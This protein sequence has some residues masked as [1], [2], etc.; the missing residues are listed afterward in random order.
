MGERRKISSGKSK[1]KHNLSK[2]NN[3]VSL[4]SHCC[5]QTELERAGYCTKHEG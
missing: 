3:L 1:K 4:F 5:L 2:V